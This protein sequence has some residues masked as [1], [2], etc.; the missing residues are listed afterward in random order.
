MAQNMPWTDFSKYISEKLTAKW[1]PAWNVVTVFNYG[2]ITINQTG[3]FR[4]V[5]YGYAFNN[6]WLWYN[7]Y[8]V[9]QNPQSPTSYIYFSFIIWKDYN[10]DTWTLQRYNDPF[11]TS[12]K[13]T[14]IKQAIK[15]LATNEPNLYTDPWLFG[16]KAVNAV[17]T[18][19]AKEAYTIVVYNEGL[20]FAIYGCVV[21]DVNEGGAQITYDTGIFSSNSKF[22]YT[23]M[24]MR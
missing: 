4:N 17:Q 10:C 22:A 11:T 9:V 2:T 6:H 16:F 23:I 8:L 18:L 7:K 19:Y 3:D 20:N 15:D 5:V 14:A 13:K 24:R 21:K 1:D 12:T